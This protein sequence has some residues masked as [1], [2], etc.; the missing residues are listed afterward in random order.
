MGLGLGLGLGFE[1]TSC[2]AVSVRPW[3]AALIESSATL[4]DAA[5]V[6]SWKLATLEVRAR[7]RDRDRVRVMI[8]VR[9]LGLTQTLIS[10][11]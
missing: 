3:P 6:A 2:A 4:G 9:R 7:A 1:R 8:R 10:T 5:A 11:A